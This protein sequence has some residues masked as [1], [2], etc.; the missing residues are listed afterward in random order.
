MLICVADVMSKETV[1]PFRGVMDAAQW[2]DGAS[3]A[4]AQPCSAQ[5]V[6]LSAG[7]LALYSSIS[8]HL[9]QRAL[10]APRPSSGFRA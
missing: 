4:G 1:A 10:R 2:E 3:T 5:D 8:L 6:K 9:A 7:H